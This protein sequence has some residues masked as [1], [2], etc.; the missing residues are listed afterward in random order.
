MISEIQ[1][2]A[3]PRLDPPRLPWRAT[4]YRAQPR[5]AAPGLP[6]YIPAA[7]PCDAPRGARLNFRFP[8]A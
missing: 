2:L 8:F 3:Q 4:P 1:N 5:R 7:T 6:G